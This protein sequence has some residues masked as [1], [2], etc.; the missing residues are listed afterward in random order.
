[1][2]SFCFFDRACVLALCLVF[3]VVVEATPGQ[4]DNESPSHS[5]EAPAQQSSARHSP[6]TRRSETGIPNFGEV[7]PNFYRGGQPTREA[8]VALKKKDIQVVIDLRGRASK[9]EEAEATKL[10]MTYIS[11]PSH[12]PFPKD[13]PWA[14]FLKTMEENSGKKVFVHCR[15]GDDRT[16]LAVATYRI[17]EEGWSADE[18]LKE[19][20]SFGF[21]R[22]HHLI[23]PGLAGYVKG[24]P[25][26][27][28]KKKAFEG[29]GVKKAK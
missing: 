12:C 16:G 22:I 9:D 17:A 20:K 15:L 13:K 10:G 5:Q 25:E 24:F 7:T 1:M 19:I 21:T 2:T 23:C 4:T 29:L 6:G 28:E 14:K 11:I 8:L 3:T 27:L 18:A 26:K